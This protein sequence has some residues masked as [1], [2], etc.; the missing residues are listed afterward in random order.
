MPNGWP[1][2]NGPIKM[3]TW[4]VTRQ[5]HGRDSGSGGPKKKKKKRTESEGKTS[6]KAHLRG[7]KN[8]EK[9]KV[10]PKVCQHPKENRRQKRPE[11][12]CGGQKQSRGSPFEA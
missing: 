11:K 2:K 9:W 12:K 3:G 4:P 7:V 10:R 8:Y 1:K 5:I 6:Q